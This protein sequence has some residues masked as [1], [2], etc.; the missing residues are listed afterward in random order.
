MTFG[1]IPFKR[2]KEL[3]FARNVAFGL[4]HLLF[5][6]DRTTEKSKTAARAFYN[7]LGRKVLLG[8]VIPD[9][10]RG[11]VWS[12][13]QK[14]SLIE[15]IWRGIPI[16]TYSVNF[17]TD[18][19]PPDLTNILI[20]GQ[21]R[22]EAIDAYWNNEFEFGGYYWKDLSELDQH[23]FVR[24]PFPQMRTNSKNRAEV[25]EYYN[26]MNFGGVAHTEEDRA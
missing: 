18:K 10:Q 24:A 9:F 7:P 2:P 21:Q 23:H 5:N 20:D 25:V 3:M 19:L 13:D 11:L 8:F 6:K 16:G 12:V 17:D 22:L 1:K 15:S 14:V 26:A 4:D